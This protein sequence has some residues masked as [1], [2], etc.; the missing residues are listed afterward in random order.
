MRERAIALLLTL[1]ILAIPSMTQ[2]ASARHDRRRRERRIRSR[3]ARC[4]RRGVQPGADRESSNG[5]D[6]RKRSVPA[7][8]IFRPGTYTVTFALPGFSTVKRDGVEVSA[9]FTSTIN[10]DMRVGAVEETITVTGESPIVDIQSAAQTRSVTAGHASRSCPSGGSWIQMAAL[11]AGHPRERHGRR[12]RA[13]RSDGR[14]GVRRTAACP[15][16]ACRCSTACVSAT[17]TS[18]R[19]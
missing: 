18:A 14:P 10:A 4:D 9:N 6:R 19:T 1:G 3:T 8:S 15:A 7:L 13:R 5:G 17:C 2:R 11:R 16:T 12:W